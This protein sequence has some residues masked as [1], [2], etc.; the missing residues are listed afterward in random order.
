MT[1]RLP[2]HVDLTGIGFASVIAPGDPERATPGIPYSMSSLAEKLVQA[3][4]ANHYVGKWDVG[5]GSPRQT[6]LQRGFESFLGYFGHSNDYYTQ[7]T[8]R[9]RDCSGCP[10][11]DLWEDNAPAKRLANRGLYIEDL[12]TNRSLGI[13]HKH[14]TH[15]EHARSSDTR[16]PLFL[17][18]AFHLVHTPLQLPPGTPSCYGEVRKGSRAMDG[19]QCSMPAR[20]IVAAMVAHLDSIVQ[21]LVSALREARLWE[22]TLMLF[23]SDNGGALGCSG[24]NNHPLMGGKTTVW[25]GGVRTVAFLSGGFLPQKVRGSHR[26]ALIH[27]ADW[28][29]TFTTLAGVSAVDPTADWLASGSRRP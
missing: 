25:E 2:A 13:I 8:V 3:G 23:V 22:S 24:G 11:I 20:R 1:G 26:D 27:I 21:L 14:A 4:Y 18:H 12:F 15:H 7:V 16:R 6:P 9:E 5:V 29:A 17:I 19:V 10:M 28:Y